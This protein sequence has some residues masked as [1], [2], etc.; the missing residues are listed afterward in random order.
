MSYGVKELIVDLFDATVLEC[1]MVRRVKMN[2]PALKHGGY[3]TTTIL[4]GESAA[5]F[6]KLR[7]DLIAELVPDGA[8]E[9]DIVATM[10][11]LV[12]RKQNL[13]TFE[14]AER[15]RDRC[16]QLLNQNDR[17]DGQP[18]PDETLRAAGEQMVE[19][20]GDACELVKMGDAA[21][22]DHLM[23]DLDVQDRLNSMIDKC[24]KRLLFVR[25]LKSIS[26]APPSAPPSRLKGPSKA[27]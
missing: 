25:G 9:E 23:N 24:L 3:S 7:R 10:A 17:Q 15:A 21:T 16:T 26:A 5:K 8:F 13:A 14:I 12:W 6:E 2:S 27:P 4:P 19:E 1:S 18:F 11:R 22:I 20:F